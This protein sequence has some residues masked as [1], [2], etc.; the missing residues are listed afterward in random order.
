MSALAQGPAA[1]VRRFWELFDT[2]RFDELF[3]DVI[4]PDCEFVM[5]G[6]PPMKG[7]AAIRGMFEAYARAFPDFRCTPIHGIESGDTFAGEA[8]FTGTHRAAL[9]TP[10]GEIPPTNKEISWLSADIVRTSGG[11]IASWHI[12]NDPLAIMTQLGVPM[13]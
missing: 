4:T 5:S 6:A 10:Q 8:R 9:V 3:H 2:R 11:K 7:P 13:G 1:T 12:Y